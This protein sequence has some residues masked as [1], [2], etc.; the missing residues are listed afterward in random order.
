ML[1]DGSWEKP[2]RPRKRGEFIPIEEVHQEHL[3]PD[4]HAGPATPE[5]ELIAQE[6]EREA[7]SRD[8]VPD[9]SKFEHLLIDPETGQEK[10]REY[11]EKQ[12]R[13]AIARFTAGEE[14]DPEPPVRNQGPNSSGSRTRSA[15][16]GWRGKEPRKHQKGGE[17][18]RKRN[19]RLEA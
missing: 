16:Q 17:T 7:G 11:Y 10:T 4:F 2:Q 1:E 19:G 9:Y 18:I 15:S 13:E 6:E 12:L 3:H 5:E 8:D 14:D